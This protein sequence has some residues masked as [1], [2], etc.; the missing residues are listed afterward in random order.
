MKYTERILTGILIS[1]FVSPVFAAVPE[2]SKPAIK[3][4]SKIL[5]GEGA[6]F[7][8]LAGTGFTLLDVRR[9]ADAKKKVERL[10]MDVGDLQGAPLKGLPGY[11]FAELK[12]NPSQLVIDFSQM[13]NSHIEL[14]TLQNR[15]K[16]SLAVKGANLTLDPVDNS[17]S[18]TLDLKKNTKVR[19]Y[20]VAGKKSTSKVVVD[21]ISE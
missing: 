11:Y 21:L 19:V 2:A 6:S 8:G 5:E 13:P 14:K 1:C 7:G 10:V 4:A 12:K 9:T 15:F 16:D 3:P 17:L 18:V 20:Q